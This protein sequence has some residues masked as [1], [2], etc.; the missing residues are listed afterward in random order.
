MF[1]KSEILHTMLEVDS[2]S[3]QSFSAAAKMDGDRAS[4]SLNG[5]VLRNSR[6]SLIERRLL[7]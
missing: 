4:V 6:G 2:R 3:E 7:A 1:L 5:S